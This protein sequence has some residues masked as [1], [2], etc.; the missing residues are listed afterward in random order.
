MRQEHRAGEKAFIDY[1]DG[2]PFVDRMTGET[3][4]HPVI[5]DRL[6]RFQ[7]YLRRFYPFAET[8]RLDRLPRA[9]LTVFWLRPSYSGPGLS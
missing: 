9:V 6:G 2:I 7:L 1:C 8:S 3:C 4:P 5:R